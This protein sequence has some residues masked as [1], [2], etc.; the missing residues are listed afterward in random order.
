MGL[1]P[2]FIANLPPE[3][4][5]ELIQN[6][7]FRAANTGQPPPVRAPQREPEA[8]DVASIIATVHDPALRREM[9]QNLGQEQVDAL[10]SALRTE[11]MNLRRGGGAFPGPP[12]PHGG[13]PRPAGYLEQLMRGPRG[14]AGGAAAALERQMDWLRRGGGYPEEPSRRQLADPRDMPFD[15]L[16]MEYTRDLDQQ[17]QDE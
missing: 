13:M 10:P 7:S 2:D 17:L 1:D 6:E 5:R 3:M 12:R 15:A 11:A 14:G 8:M 9:L 4:R 16:L